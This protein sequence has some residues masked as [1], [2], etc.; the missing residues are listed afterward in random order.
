MI[1]RCKTSIAMLSHGLVN[2]VSV[3]AVV[4]VVNRASLDMSA[5][6]VAHP[7]G[8]VVDHVG[9]EVGVEPGLV[10]PQ[11]AVDALHGHG[12][13]VV[14]L[15]QRREVVLHPPQAELSHRGPQRAVASDGRGPGRGQ[16]RGR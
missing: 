16:A 11:L 10:G 13:D 12:V 4:H 9:A 6:V 7:R 15:V 1:G 3:L 5:Y 2:T 8:L 14:N